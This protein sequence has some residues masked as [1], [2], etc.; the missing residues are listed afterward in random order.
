VRAR[1]AARGS[2]TGSRAAALPVR[3]RAVLAVVHLIF[4]E[5]YTASSGDRLVR[6]DRCTE[7]IRL[8]RLL[9]EFIPDEAVAEVAGPEAALTLV[10]CLNLV[11]YDVVHAVRSDLFRRPDRTDKAAQEYETAH[12]RIENAI[13]RDLLRRIRAAACRGG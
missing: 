5:G 8:G 11:G 6:E 1:F 7:A 2:L 4:N 9:A 3:L 12:T 13:E 10:D